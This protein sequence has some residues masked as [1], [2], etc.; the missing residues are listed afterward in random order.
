MSDSVVE[1]VQLTF[2]TLV[3]HEALTTVAGTITVTLHGN[4][5]HRVTVTGWKTTKDRRRR[6]DKH[7]RNLEMPLYVIC[8]K[9][10]EDGS[11][12]S[13]DA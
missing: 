7:L 11:Q 5:A 2:V 13:C 8:I 1:I 10:L 12:C 6:R 9:G 3:T 4:G